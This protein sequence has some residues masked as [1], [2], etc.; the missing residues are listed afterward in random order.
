MKVIGTLGAQGWYC[1]QLDRLADGRAPD[2]ERGV[3][4]SFVRCWWGNLSR[5]ARLQR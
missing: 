4:R 5:A 2:L 1:Q 3:L